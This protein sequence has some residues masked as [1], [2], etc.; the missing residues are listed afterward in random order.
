MAWVAVNWKNNQEVI[1]TNRPKR[2][3]FRS[4]NYED[5]HEEVEIGFCETSEEYGIDL[6]KGTI[7]KLI[8]REMTF[9]D[10]PIELNSCD[11]ISKDDKEIIIG[12]FELISQIAENR[13]TPYGFRMEDSDVLDEIQFKAKKCAECVKNLVE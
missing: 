1:F 5:W 9:M 7:K 11:K 6:P 4:G 8:G 2:I 3:K 10:E 12:W 13:I